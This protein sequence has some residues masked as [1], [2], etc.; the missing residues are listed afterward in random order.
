MTTTTETIVDLVQAIREVPY[1]W[2]GDPH[3]AT[4]RHTGRGTCASKHALLQA[5][6][7]R[8]GVLSRPM[9][10]IGRLVPD[11]L[12]GDPTFTPFAHL[13]EVHE[14]LTVSVPGF[15]PCRVDVTW[16][17]PLLRAG[18]PG[19][20]AWDGRTD[21]EL[22]VGATTQTWAPAPLNLRTEKELLRARLYTSVDRR[23]R[24]TALAE[25]STLF[26]RWR[27]RRQPMVGPV[28]IHAGP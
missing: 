12:L 26:D 4:A 8:I 5:E 27:S 23:L 2:P 25:M 11:V 3:A 16:D 28:R 20:L 15:G 19:R 17:P 18:L 13:C 24:D 1:R 14:F 22:A 7:Q 21:M 10:A 9:F 6:L